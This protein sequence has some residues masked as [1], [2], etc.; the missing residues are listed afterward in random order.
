M[1]LQTSYLQLP[2]LEPHSKPGGTEYPEPF[3]AASLLLQLMSQDATLP[4][5]D[6]ELNSLSGSNDIGQL[7]Q[8]LITSIQCVREDI[9]AIK[10]AVVDVDYEDDSED[11]MDGDDMDEDDLSDEEDSSTKPPAAKAGPF[12]SRVGQGMYRRYTPRS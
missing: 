8:S 3:K 10:E 6:S 1:S 9:A 7:L 12:G 2:Q 11:D 5:Q 4:I